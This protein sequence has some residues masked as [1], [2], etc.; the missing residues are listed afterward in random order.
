MPSLT[1]S[2]WAE[3]RD[4]LMYQPAFPL[5]QEWLAGRD[6]ES[7]RVHDEYLYNVAY[8]YTSAD[9]ARSQASEAVDGFLYFP[10]AEPGNYRL[11]MPHLNELI[12]GGDACVREASSSLDAALLLVNHLASLKVAQTK[13]RWPKGPLRRALVKEGGTREL[14]ELLDQIFNSIGYKMLDGYRNWATHRGA[15]RII[16]PAKLAEV[17]E[18]EPWQSDDLLR[19]EDDPEWQERRRRFHIQMIIQ[20]ALQVRC[21]PFVP[22]AAARFSAQ[23]GPSDQAVEIAGVMRIE[24][25]AKVKIDDMVLS[26]GKLIDDADTWAK[27]NPIAPEEGYAIVAG[28]KL[29]TFGYYD[30]MH[31]LATVL[32]FLEQT[33]RGDLDRLVTDLAGNAIAQK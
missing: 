27:N 30:Y 29:A 11:G 8:H 22:S 12:R 26:T 3:V 5:L 16:V 20:K 4:V 18:L 28:E 31:A 23:I 19:F 13:I 24:P 9:E 25:G 7:R 32:S 21:W 2:F 1:A 33:F 10:T 6:P 14:T 15:P 17:V